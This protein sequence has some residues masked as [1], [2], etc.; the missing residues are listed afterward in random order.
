MTMIHSAVRK[1]AFDGGHI[2]V[3]WDNHENAAQWYKE[4]TDWGAEGPSLSN[5]NNGRPYKARKKTRLW[6]GTWLV[7][8]IT[9][10]KIGHLAADRGTVDPHVR[11]CWE[12]RKLAESHALF[13]QKGVRVTPLYTGPDDG[14]YF[15]FWATAEGTRLTAC[16]A[17][18]LPADSPR[19]ANGRVRIGVS[20]LRSA[21]QWY[22]EYAG[23]EVH[24]D[25]S[26]DGFVIMKLAL[27]HH[28]EKFSSWCLEQLQPGAYTGKADGPARPYVV[29]H[30]HGAFTRYHA[31]LQDSGVAVSDIWDEGFQSY[32]HLYDPDGNRFNVT[33]Y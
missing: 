32:F 11:W 17:L 29:V 30:D 16:E 19:F 33:K 23:M 27:E 25:R 8:F 6:Y 28:P 10:E 7:S 31:F 14:R 4:F 5:N 12:T 9:E 2:D 24:E 13:E 21:M 26:E 20:D 1:L 15:D 3:L 18:D 22:R